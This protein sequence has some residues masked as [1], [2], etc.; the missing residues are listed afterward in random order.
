MSTPVKT[1]PSDQKI[2][3]AKKVL[4]KLRLK[5]APVIEKGRMI[6]V[7]TLNDIQKAMK[8][9]YEHASVKGYMSRSVI[10]VSPDVPLHLIQKIMF[11]KNIGRLPVLKKKKLIGIVTRTDVLKTVHRDIFEKAEPLKKRRTRFNISTKMKKMLPREILKILHTIGGTA[12]LEGLRAFVVGGFVRDLLLGV[13]NFD[14]D[15]VLEG[16]AISFGKKIAKLLNGSYVAYKKFGTSSVVINWPKGLRIPGTSNLTLRQA[17]GRPEHN[18]GAK[19]KLD[20]ATARKE[21]YE[22]PAAL[23]T[24][25]FSL[26]KDDLHRRDFTI[27][28]MAAS[29]N[30]GSFSQLID[31]FGGE[32]DLEKGIIKVLHDGS[33]IDDPTRI[34]RAV[35]FEQR[36]GFRIDRYTRDLIKR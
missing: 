35:R 36:F 27:N 4:K 10:T 5:G 23:P 8:H 19:F 7:I 13:K 14:I 24:V 29:L 15:I 9:H 31:F 25:Q 2:R 11:E 32:R 3:S 18:R 1:I 6:G 26:L 20:F 34:F 16:D 21:S 17:Q 28:A 12:D 22:K 33:F 30:K